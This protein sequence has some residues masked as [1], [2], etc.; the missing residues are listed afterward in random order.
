MGKRRKKRRRR[1]RHAQPSGNVT[2]D[3]DSHP[4]GTYGLDWDDDYA[5]IA[6]FTSAG[7]AFGTP[8]AEAT[9]LLDDPEFAEIV[10]AAQEDAA[11]LRALRPM[12]HDDALGINRDHDLDRELPF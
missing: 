3:P 2:Q 12:S 4:L 9:Y 6:G 11:Y 1:R 8:W 10:T 5:F 7:Y